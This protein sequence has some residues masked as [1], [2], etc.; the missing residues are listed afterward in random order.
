VD[1]WDRVRRGVQQGEALRERLVDRDH[2]LG[3][4]GIAAGPRHRVVECAAVDVLRHR[5]VAMRQVRVE[6]RGNLDDTSLGS[7]RGG[8]LRGF[9]FE[10]AAE[11][12]E[13]PGGDGAR[14]K[15]EGDAG[16]DGRDR[17]RGDDGTAA[18]PALDREPPHVREDRETFT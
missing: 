1:E 10:R 4:Q 6:R 14:L 8:E 18:A 5:V 13:L 17:R 9:D 15:E 11:L 3:E 16:R 12:A 2:C 7:T